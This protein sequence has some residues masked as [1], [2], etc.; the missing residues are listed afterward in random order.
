MEPLKYHWSNGTYTLFEDYGI[1]KFGNVKN[2]E[3]GQMTSRH[4][5]NKYNIVAISHEGKL[6]TIRVARAIAS[7]FLGPPPTLEHT[8]DHIDQDS[9]NDTV[10]NIRWASKSEQNHNRNK[11]STNKSAFIIVKGGMEHTIKEWTEIFRKPNGE[12]V[13]II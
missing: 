13:C 7:T 11:P 8:A 9:L 1:D 10:E 5:T 6:R 4:D 2:V 3:I 12:R